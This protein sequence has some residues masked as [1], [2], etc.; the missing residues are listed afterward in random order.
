MQSNQP[1][2][3]IGE[4][5]PLSPLR[6]QPGHATDSGQIANVSNFAPRQDQGH[7]QHALYTPLRGVLFESRSHTLIDGLKHPQGGGR[8]L[9]GLHYG[10]HPTAG[11]HASLVEK[12]V[13]LIKLL[14]V[15]LLGCCVMTG[16]CIPVILKEGSPPL[17]QKPMELGP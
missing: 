5:H 16:N 8:L 14:D 11:I 17:T 9:L 13:L 7:S 12:E 2:N 15:E 1:L 6:G 4:P 10:A 3:S